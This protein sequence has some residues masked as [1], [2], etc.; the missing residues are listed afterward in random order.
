MPKEIFDSKTTTKNYLHPHP[1]HFVNAT[2]VP[3]NRPRVCWPKSELPNFLPSRKSC[4]GNRWWFGMKTF[5]SDFGWCNFKTVNEPQSGSWQWNCSFTTSV[6]IKLSCPREVHCFGTGPGFFEKGY[7]QSTPLK[8]YNGKTNLQNHHWKISKSGKIHPVPTIWTIHDL[9]G[10]QVDAQGP[11]VR[12]L[13]TAKIVGNQCTSGGFLWFVDVN[14]LFFFPW[15]GIKVSSPPIDEYFPKHKEPWIGVCQT[16]R[17]RRRTSTTLCLKGVHPR[18]LTCP[19]KRDY[20][21]REY[22]FQPLIFRGHVSFQGSIFL[23]G[24]GYLYHLGMTKKTPANRWN[25]RPPLCVAWLV[26]LF[27]DP[28]DMCATWW[29]WELGLLFTPTNHVL[30]CGKWTGHLISVCRRYI[31]FFTKKPKVMGGSIPG[32]SWMVCIFFVPKF[33]KQKTLPI[34][35]DILHTLR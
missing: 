17:S 28:R 34:W 12:L 25:R 35:A 32:S 6:D 23:L 31:R 21:S 24:H 26:D 29:L 3:Q 27:V 15:W 10:Y 18:K 8:N 20:F 30:F 5:G 4:W 11:K 19:L 16:Q 22:I 9:G 7:L 2:S 33:K 1:L 14:F 13:V